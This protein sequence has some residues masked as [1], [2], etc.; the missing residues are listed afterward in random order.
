MKWQADYDD[1]ELM[2]STCAHPTTAESL[3]E[4]AEVA[5]GHPIHIAPKKPNLKTMASIDQYPPLNWPNH[6]NSKPKVIITWSKS[7]LR[8]TDQIMQ[9]R[10]WIFWIMDLVKKHSI[11]F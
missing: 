6:D 8:T 5:L 2:D 7:G 1:N 9:V 4:A 11:L 10:R 3:M